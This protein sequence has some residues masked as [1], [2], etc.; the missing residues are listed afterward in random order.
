M[1]VTAAT[2]LLQPLQ[3]TR[4]QGCGGN[5]VLTRRYTHLALIFLLFQRLYTLPAHAADA[6]FQ[7][8]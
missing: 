1:M 2:Q 8:S 4:E 3:V 7:G 5:L 6:S